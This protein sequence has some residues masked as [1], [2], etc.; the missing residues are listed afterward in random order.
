ML[1]VLDER[2]YRGIVA[3]DLETHHPAEAALLA[4]CETVLWMAFKALIIDL[5]Y[6]LLLV[7]Y[8][9][10]N[11][12]TFFVLSK[13]R[14]QRPESAQRQ[15]A[16]EGR[17]RESKTVCPP[18]Q[19]LVQVRGCRDDRSTYDVAV[20]IDVFGCRVNNNVGTEGN[21]LLQRWRQEC[22]VDREQC[23]AAFRVF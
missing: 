17:T 22:V 20:A 21:R 5:L 7:E 16:V 14:M 10:Q 4:R 8:V 15:V 9:C 18:A 11:V 6:H 23:A 12:R 1:E 19:P 2:L 3:G 13:T